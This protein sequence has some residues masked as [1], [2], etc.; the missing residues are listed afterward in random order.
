MKN[1]WKNSEKSMKNQWTSLLF[2]EQAWKI[3]EWAW[4]RM[5]CNHNEKKQRAST[6]N[7][8]LCEFFRKYHF[9]LGQSGASNSKLHFRWWR[10]RL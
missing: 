10:F 4:K 5:F 7:E 8:T 2:N 3:N 9:C 1:Q 6:K